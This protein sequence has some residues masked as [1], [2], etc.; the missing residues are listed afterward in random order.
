MARS[1]ENNYCNSRP[2]PRLLN[3]LFTG[4]GEKKI[5]PRMVYISADVEGDV[6]FLNDRSQGVGLDHNS[7]NTVSEE[8]MYMEPLQRKLNEFEKCQVTSLILV[9]WGTLYTRVQNPFPYLHKFTRI[10]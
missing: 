10:N 7:A 3:N 6:C 1:F 9:C 2:D 8:K 5:L 4:K